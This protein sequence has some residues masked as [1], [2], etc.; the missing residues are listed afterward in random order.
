MIIRT[1]KKKIYNMEKQKTKCND[2]NYIKLNYD[3]A[4]VLYDPPHFKYINALVLNRYSFIFREK[5]NCAVPKKVTC[6]LPLLEFSVREE[7][8]AQNQTWK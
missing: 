3:Q 2:P 1:N 7:G 5:L 8:T 4:K 6:K